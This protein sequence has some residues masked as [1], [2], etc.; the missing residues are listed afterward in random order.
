MAAARPAPTVEESALRLLRE[1]VGTGC[2]MHDSPNAECTTCGA[3]SL[4]EANGR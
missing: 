4:L 2:P 3:V 1:L